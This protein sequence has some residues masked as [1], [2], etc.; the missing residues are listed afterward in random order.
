MVDGDPCEG[1]K[2]NVTSPTTQ[3]ID[4][5]VIP[6]GLQFSFKTTATGQVPPDQTLI[7]KSV[8]QLEVA[9]DLKAQ[10]KVPEA[11]TVDMS[12]LI[13]NVYTQSGVSF[14][15]CEGAGKCLQFDNLSNSFLCMDS[16]GGEA[17]RFTT[18][19]TP[20]GTPPVADSTSDTIT[21]TNGPAITVTGDATTDTVTIAVPDGGVTGTQIANSTIA[22]GKLSA[23]GTPG[24]S[25]F[26]RG[27]NSWAAVNFSNLVGTATSTQVPLAATATALAAN[28][29][30]CTLGQFANA[31]AAN[32]D[33]TCATP[34]GGGGGASLAG[35]TD[36]LSSTT[37][38]ART[39][40]NG[41][42]TVVRVEVFPETTI[43]TDEGAAATAGTIAWAEAQLTGGGEVY[44]HAGTYNVGTTITMD[45]AGT[46]LRCE[47][48]Q[49]TVLTAKTNLNSTILNVGWAGAQ[50][51]GMQ[52]IGC[53]FNGN[54]ANQSTSGTLIGLKDVADSR[55]EGNYFRYWR[56]KGMTIGC[57]IGVVGAP[58]CVEQMISRNL[59]YSSG[60]PTGSA[61]SAI[62][63]VTDAGKPATDSHIMYND[64]G[65]AANDG[66]NTSAWI[67]IGNG[68]AIG[69]NGW[70]LQGNHVYGTDRGP[71]IEIADLQA[72]TIDIQDNTLESCT[73]AIKWTGDA[74]GSAGWSLIQGNKMYGYSRQCSAVGAGSYLGKRCAAD[75]DCGTGGTCAVAGPAVFDFN[76][77]LRNTVT[78]NQFRSQQGGVTAFIQL[79]D[80][81]ALGGTN[82][83]LISLN[84]MDFTVAGE[85]GITLANSS[86]NNVISAN[87]CRGIGG[88]GGGTCIDG[89]SIGGNQFLSNAC[90]N[91]CTA[92]EAPGTIPA[93]SATT[94]HD[95]NTSSGDM[96]DFT[97]TAGAC[98]VDA[99]AISNAKLASSYSGVG[100]CAANTFASTLT[101]NAAPTCTQPSF[102]NLSG[103]ATSTQVPLAQTATALAADPSDCAANMFANIIQASGNLGCALVNHGGLSGLSADD[104]TQYT[105]KAGRTGGTNNTTLSSDASGTLNGSGASGG[106]LNLTANTVGTGGAISLQ[107]PSIVVPGT[108]N[109]LFD[110]DSTAAQTFITFTDG[111]ETISNLVTGI[112]FAGGT[113]TV[114]SNVAGI[115]GLSMP[116]SATVS[117]TAATNPVFGAIANLFTANAK[118]Q[119]ASGA[120]V[121]GTWATPFVA[122]HTFEASGAGTAVTQNAG[123]ADYTSTPTYAVAA[124]GTFSAGA[125]F[126]FYHKP[127]VNTGATVPNDWGLYIANAAGAG[128]LTTQSGIHIEN[129][130]AATTIGL[131]N[132]STTI[133]TAAGGADVAAGFT[134]TPT[135]TFFTILPVGASRV[136]S[137]TTAITDAQDGQILYIS[138]VGATANTVT[139]KDVANTDFGGS[140]CV[141]NRGGVLQVIFSAQESVWLKVS[142]SPN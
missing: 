126:G 56:K 128:T 38:L 25:N 73:G 76:R 136:S 81:G 12:E 98:T 57:S 51:Q 39:F 137:V 60:G 83:N 70:S 92:L 13:A 91:V 8:I 79:R 20:L 74:T 69:T 55:I 110:P 133:Y 89:G 127:T 121:S 82:H 15:D 131:R 86:T 63:I 85:K 1:C 140:D 10:V 7:Q 71:C 28:P 130:T 104:H 3:S 108:A 99:G 124:G 18:V 111:T 113:Y 107:A 14:V 6:K 96:G 41:A 59:F 42:G 102:A 53:G 43:K 35:V 72:N 125:R 24:A 105:L 50:R 61:G 103:T 19:Q 93:F 54:P 84:E 101:A 49:T 94:I 68:T 90:N 122:A 138:N 75:A 9:G 36:I 2:V 21:L 31:I 80:S 40:A 29:A 112:Q 32:G 120:A 88:G 48:P 129:L 33:L 100:V 37:L 78:S 97:C 5:I 17:F 106:G 23:T 66:D 64:I 116:T 58:Q 44:L 52:V 118:I 34:A 117:Y 11:S 46:T 45:I 16:C 77:V 132:N 119:I 115:T 65:G 27:D 47:D 142:C 134:I 135:S 87:R 95:V 109:L 30:D 139:I 141:L 4:G 26:L 22:V 123:S 67:K 62:E 114:N